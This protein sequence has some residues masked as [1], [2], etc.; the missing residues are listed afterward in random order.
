MT[1]NIDI[2]TN[3]KCRFIKNVESSF[4]ISVVPVND[5]IIPIIR[6]VIDNIKITL[7]ISFHHLEKY[8]FIEFICN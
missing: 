3:I 8:S 5:N 4:L 6:R 1:N 7:S 2:D